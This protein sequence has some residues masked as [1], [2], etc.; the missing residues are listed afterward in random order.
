[1]SVNR[2]SMLPVIIFLALPCVSRAKDDP[3]DPI[4]KKLEECID[5]NTTT[6]GMVNCTIQSAAAWDKEM[7]AVYSKLLSRLDEKSKEALQK[8]QRQWLNYRDNEIA[9]IAAYY[10]G[11][12]GTMYIPMRVVQ[13]S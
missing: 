1:M 2:L 11:F 5:K 13:L 10:D 9:F 8:S 12:Q 6:A 3:I 4:E 7:N